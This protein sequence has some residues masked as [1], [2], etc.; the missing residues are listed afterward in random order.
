LTIDNIINTIDTN[1]VF[2]TEGHLLVLPRKLTNLTGSNSIYQFCQKYIPN[3]FIGGAA[4]PLLPGWTT[5]CKSFVGSLE[6]D[7]LEYSPNPPKITSPAIKVMY[8]TIDDIF[9]RIIRLAIRIF[10]LFTSL[11]FFI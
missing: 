2:N 9:R 10:V 5:G 3:P 4:T 11:T 7:M 1:A 8:D 6:L